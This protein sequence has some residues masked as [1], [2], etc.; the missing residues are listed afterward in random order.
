[1][2]MVW[3]LPDPPT[4]RFCSQLLLV[5][6]QKSSVNSHSHKI[7]VNIKAVNSYSYSVS[8][9]TLTEQ[10]HETSILLEVHFKYV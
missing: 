8:V 5:I 2:N 4:K 1:M 7:S 10:K 9:N 3:H 6:P